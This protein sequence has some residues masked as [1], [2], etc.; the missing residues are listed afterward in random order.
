MSAAL[1]A[2]GLTLGYG[3]RLILDDVD[4]TLRSGESAAL[5]G[6]NGAGKTTLLRALA[7]VA[8]LRRGRVMVGE[9]DTARADRRTLARRVGFATQHAELHV[10]L[11]A[12]DV[13]ALGLYAHG[14][15][16]R[17]LDEAERARVSEALEAFGVL[18]CAERAMPSLSG[19]EQQRVRLAA[20]RVQA[21]PVLLLDEPTSAQDLDGTAKVAAWMR[22]HCADGGAVLAA[23]HDLGLALRGFDRVVVLGGG[24]VLADGPPHEVATSDALREAYGRAP[25]VLRDTRGDLW[26]APPLAH[27]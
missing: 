5:V 16:W 10:P 12:W 22:G 6:G 2:T 18:A 13:A 21:P 19:G 11:R 8:P 9:L 17:A 26:V 3:E 20:L 24:R 15:S 25:D 7:G 1:Q 14:A 27:D 23:V 4:L